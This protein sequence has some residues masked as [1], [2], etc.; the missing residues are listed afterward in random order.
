LIAARAGSPAQQSDSLRRYG[1]QVAHTVR[2]VSRAVAA[3][4]LLAMIGG[5]IAYLPKIPVRGWAGLAANPG[6]GAI[7][8]L[9]GPAVASL[10][11]LGQTPVGLVAMSLGLLALAAL[12]AVTVLLILVQN[13]RHRRW[14]EALIAAGVTGILMLSVLLK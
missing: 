2:R 8:A 12:P 7:G 14:L 10:A 11:R 3:P 1:Q 5:L 4:A 9:P 13:L 6:S